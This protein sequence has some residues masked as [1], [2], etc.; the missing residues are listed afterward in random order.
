MIRID[1]KVKITMKP[2]QGR[3]SGNLKGPHYPKG[4]H[5]VV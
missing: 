2:T 5:K 4:P 1:K 3:K